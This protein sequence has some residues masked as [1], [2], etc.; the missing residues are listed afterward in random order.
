MN[1]RTVVVNFAANGPIRHGN[2]VLNSRKWALTLT[3]SKIWTI[4]I[5]ERVAWWTSQ[6][7]VLGVS[8]DE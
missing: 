5:L 2:C 6:L 3:K 1:N 4:M 7:N 8:L